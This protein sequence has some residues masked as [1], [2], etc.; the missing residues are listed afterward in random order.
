MKSVVHF[1]YKPLSFSPTSFV[2]RF[3][4]CLFE[5][6][7][8]FRWIKQ[9][10]WNEGFL[11]RMWGGRFFFFESRKLEFLEEGRAVI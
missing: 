1:T 3:S 6:G 10:E 2:P 9:R 7:K 4:R 5:E 8:C 11:R